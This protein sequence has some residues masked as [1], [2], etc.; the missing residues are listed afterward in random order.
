[1]L[2]PESDIQFHFCQDPLKAVEMAN[3]IRPTVIL[4]DLVMPDIDGMTLMLSHGPA[5]GGVTL[6]WTGGQPTFNVFRS[7]SPHATLELD[8]IGTSLL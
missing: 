3:Q 7:T 5:P 1:M 8:S 2:Q 6:K 4:Q